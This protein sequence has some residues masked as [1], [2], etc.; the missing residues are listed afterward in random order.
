MFEIN[1]NYIFTSSKTGNAPFIPEARRP[2]PSRYPCP[3]CLGDAPGIR[4]AD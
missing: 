4:A 3:I 1:E 2:T